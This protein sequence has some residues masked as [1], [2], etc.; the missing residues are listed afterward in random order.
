MT[1]DKKYISMK[2]IWHELPCHNGKK[3]SRQSIG[4]LYLYPRIHLYNIWFHAK[5]CSEARIIADNLR[6]FIT[7][8]LIKANSFSTNPVQSNRHPEVNYPQLKQ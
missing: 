7:L 6:I 1:V 4:Q 2:I 5:T 3:H 8:I